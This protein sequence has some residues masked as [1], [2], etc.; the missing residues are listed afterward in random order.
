MGMTEE[1]KIPF[2]MTT[3]CLFLNTEFQEND[4]KPD[5]FVKELVASVGAH[6]TVATLTNLQTGSM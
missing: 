5:I 1:H 3:C 2:E 6:T 4:N